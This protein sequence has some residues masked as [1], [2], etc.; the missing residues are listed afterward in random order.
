MVGVVA[1]VVPALVIVAVAVAI[2]ASQQQARSR[3]RTNFGMKGATAAAFVDSYV[4]EE[5]HQEIDA[6]TAYLSG[7]SVSPAQCAVVNRVLGFTNATLLDAQGRVLDSA[8]A[9]AGAAGATV[10]SPYLVR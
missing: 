9:T 7:P 3:V 5:S 8:P 6:A 4:T 10:S 2:V 1:F